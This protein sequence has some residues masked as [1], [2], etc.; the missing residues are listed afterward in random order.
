MGFAALSPVPPAQLNVLH[1]KFTDQAGRPAGGGPSHCA[2]AWEL[3]ALFGEL[4]VLQ[5][6]SIKFARVCKAQGAVTPF[7]RLWS[8]REYC[9]R[10]NRAN[11][12]NRKFPPLVPHSQKPVPLFLLLENGPLGAP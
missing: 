2:A 3:P 4:G 9:G 11:I 8:H 6:E 5:R 7:W 10:S 12:H 1:L